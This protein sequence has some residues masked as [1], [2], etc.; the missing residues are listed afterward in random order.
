MGV[1]ILKNQHT[2]LDVQFNL[3]F[4]FSEIYFFKIPLLTG[5][6]LPVLIGG[7]H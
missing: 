5:G 7:F 6:F 1:R 3:F 2:S 4:F